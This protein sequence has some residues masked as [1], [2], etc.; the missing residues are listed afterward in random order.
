MFGSCRGRSQLFPAVFR[1]SRNML[2][3]IK[4]R[5]YPDPRL[6]QMKAARARTCA[7]FTSRT[8]LRRFIPVQNPYHFHA[9]APSAW[10]S[11]RARPFAREIVGLAYFSKL[12]FKTKTSGLSICFWWMLL[13]SLFGVG[14]TSQIKMHFPETFLIFVLLKHLKCIFSLQNQK[15]TPYFSRPFHFMIVFEH[16]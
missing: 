9:Y 2:K 1:V 5:I 15:P 3:P 6:A 4:H 16:L 8:R 7:R 11:P 12:L 14:M 13:P 10:R